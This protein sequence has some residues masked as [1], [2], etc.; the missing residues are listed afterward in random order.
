M[1]HKNKDAHMAARKDRAGSCLADALKG[2]AEFAQHVLEVWKEDLG[3]TAHRFPFDAFEV[4]GVDFDFHWADPELSPHNRLSATLCI[5]SAQ[6]FGTGLVD[7]K[8]HVAFTSWVQACAASASDDLSSPLWRFQRNRTT[9][10]VVVSK[11]VLF[12]LATKSVM[13]FP[14][15]RGHLDKA[16]SSL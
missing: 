4:T 10:H 3:E 15:N 8:Y 13:T 16:I 7:G 2:D 9:A 12:G 5:A 14:H 6:I 1:V 11:K